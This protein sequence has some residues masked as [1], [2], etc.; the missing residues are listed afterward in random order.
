MRLI[1]RQVVVASVVATM[2]GS[3]LASV[4]FSE[5]TF[6]A[7]VFEKASGYFSG[8]KILLVSYYSRFVNII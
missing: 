8:L 4:G 6:T 5:V 1:T 2:P 7:E 3:D